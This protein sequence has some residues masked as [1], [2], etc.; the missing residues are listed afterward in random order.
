[1][2]PIQYRLMGQLKM[3]I[4]EL[5]DEIIKSGDMDDFELYKKLG[6]ELNKL[7]NQRDN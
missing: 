5:K 4:K 6:R 3:E 7:K 2:E 1:M